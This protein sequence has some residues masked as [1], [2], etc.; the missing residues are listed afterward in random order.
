MVRL[1]IIADDFTGAL[2]TGVKF[3]EEGA[4]TKVVAGTGWDLNRMENE[5]PEVLVVNA[6]TRHLAAGEA[7]QVVY[8]IVKKAK[9][10]GAVSYTHLTLPTN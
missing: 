7:Y 10:A 5:A 9:D 4:V 8:R 1:L 3:A 2:D 6:E